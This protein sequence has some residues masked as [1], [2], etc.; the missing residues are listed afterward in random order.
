VVENPCLGRELL[1]AV[2]AR[3]R[4]ELRCPARVTAP[5]RT[6]ACMWSSVARASGIEC[7]ATKPPLDE[8]ACDLLVIADGAESALR[9]KLGFFTRRKRYGERALIANLAFE[10][11]HR[12]VPTSASPPAAPGAAAAAARPRKRAIAWPWCGPCRRLRPSR[13]EQ[14]D[15]ETLPRR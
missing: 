4:I 14:A 6:G 7:G 2:R 15:D 8:E 11:D 5:P 9:E 10:T 13:L 1:A 3:P 12:A